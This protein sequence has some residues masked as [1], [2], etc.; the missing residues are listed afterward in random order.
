[1]CVMS[2]NTISQQPIL[3]VADSPANPTASQENGKPGQTTGISG[4]S[5]PVLFASVNPNGCWLKM[6][7]GY[8][9]AKLDGSLVEF[10]GTW[11]QAGMVL[12]G[13][14]YRLR[15]LVRR[16]SGRG[17][18]LSQGKWPTPQAGDANFSTPRTTGRPIEKVTHLATAAK[19]WPTP[20]VSRGDYQYSQ[21]NHNKRSLKLSGAVKMIPTPT[22]RDWRSGKASQ[23]TMERNSR[24]LSEVIGGQLNP[25][26]VEWLM[27]FPD[28]WT[29]LE[30]SETP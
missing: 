27:G 29:D 12:N 18:L 7:Q 30:D 11:P 26:W 8:Y 2:E 6:S 22:S 19:Y 10:S 24:P 9:L 23:E 16:I 13:K 5:S 21:G 28:G 15:R 14:V 25:R 4:P 3:F 1:M 20:T 17:S